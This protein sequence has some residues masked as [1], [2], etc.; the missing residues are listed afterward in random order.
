MK[1]WFQ[2]GVGAVLAGWLLAAQSTAGTS[3]VFRLQTLIKGTKNNPGAPATTLTITDTQLINLSLGLPVNNSAPADVRL[4]L[5]TH[6]ASN[7]LRIIVY[8]QATQSNLVT[9]GN[10]QTVSVVESLR[11]TR[12]TRNVISELTLTVTN[13]TAELFTG[14]ICYAAG[15]ILSDSN[16]CFRS[17]RAN[18]IGALVSSG[19]LTNIN[20]ASTTLTASG[21]QL[22][23]LIE[24]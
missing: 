8:N 2:W 12:Y 14:G 15:S 24:P 10:L 17:Y 19:F 7:D 11:G 3:D 4:G 13:G 18:I 5:V 6:C 16:Q 22:G 1:S 21:K 20:I 23:I 9:I